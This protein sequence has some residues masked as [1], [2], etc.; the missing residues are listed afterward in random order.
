MGQPTILLK[1][2]DGNDN[3]IVLI[4]YETRLIC[5]M[6][7]G[8]RDFQ[9]SISIPV[10][11]LILELDCAGKFEDCIEGCPNLILIR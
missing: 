1:L 6:K 2:K 7:N 5:K 11:L 10:F 9:K 3:F 4:K 8:E